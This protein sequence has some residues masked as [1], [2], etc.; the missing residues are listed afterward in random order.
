[1]IIDLKEFQTIAQVHA[2]IAKEMK[3]PDYYGANLD[4]LYDMLNEN[5]RPITI[6]IFGL[7]EIDG[8][9]AED[10]NHMLDMF[11]YMQDE[12]EKFHCMIDGYEL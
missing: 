7:N 5:I 6:E 12:N 3:F 2:H 10:M 8:Q 4:A 1:M 9:F 11:E